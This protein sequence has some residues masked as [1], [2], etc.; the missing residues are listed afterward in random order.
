LA[1]G[2]AVESVH[3][4]LGLGANAVLDGVRYT[5]LGTM[6]RAADDGSSWSE[7][8]LY[9]PG[10]KFLWLVET[11]E[12]WQRAE[13]LDNWPAWDGAGHASIDHVNFTQSSL[14]NA[15]V[16][17][18]A[19]AFNWRVNVGDRVQVTEFS[20]GNIRLAAEVTRE[21]M[22]WSRSLPVPL[23]QLRASSGAHVH[24]D[25]QPH[26][27]YMQSARRLLTAL[28]LI[29]VIPLMVAFGNVIPY[30][31]LGAAAIY[32]PAYFLDKLDTSEQ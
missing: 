6:K 15:R 29:N 27:T 22:T 23:D 13:V 31:L 3:F 8:L 25:Q 5:I 17:F 2:A 28:L 24:A 21:E 12:G 10:R 32:L 26:P 4:T 7:Y 30:A 11:D 19:G 9:A 18:A 14:Y 16:T 20:A 1:A